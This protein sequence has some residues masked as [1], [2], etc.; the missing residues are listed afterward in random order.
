MAAVVSHDIGRRDEGRGEGSGQIVAVGVNCSDPNHI[1]VNMLC[2]SMYDCASPN[3]RVVTSIIIVVSGHPVYIRV[4][5]YLQS[6]LRSASHV[7]DDRGFI[8]YPNS[9]EMWNPQHQ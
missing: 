1:E 8:V 7:N 4:C 2:V 3:E 5:I 9:G 6:L